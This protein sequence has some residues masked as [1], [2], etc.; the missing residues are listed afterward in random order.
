MTLQSTLEVLLAV[1]ALL[2]LGRDLRRAWR[3][4]LK[5][6]I[7]LL[8]AALVAVLLLGTLGGNAH[9]DPGWLLLPAGVLAWEV[10]R[11]WH[12]TPR[13]H[14]WEAGVGAFAASLVLAA[15]GL[16]MQEDGVS[17][18]VLVTATGAGVMGLALLWR[19]RLREPRPW[20]L[21]E[22]DHYE[23]RGAQR[24]RG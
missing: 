21:D 22:P 4:P 24:K 11:G 10:W 1:A 9:P 19:S 13:C 7:S 2:L 14:V 8:V 20:R 16:E 12:H 6:P 3:D 17:T 5:R 15:V 23:R 18:A